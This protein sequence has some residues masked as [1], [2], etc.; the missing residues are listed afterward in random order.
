MLAAG[1]LDAL[2][3]VPGAEN[4]A[5]RGHLVEIVGGRGGRVVAHL[6]EPGSGQLALAACRLLLHPAKRNNHFP[7]GT[8]HGAAGPPPAAADGR[9]AAKGA[10]ACGG[11][12]AGM[13]GGAGNGGTGEK[14]EISTK[15]AGE[16][17]SIGGAPYLT[18]RP[19][20]T[21]RKARNAALAAEGARRQ[22]RRPSAPEWPAPARSARR[23][24]APP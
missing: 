18:R 21:R 2:G 11:R 19:P 12:P 5:E 13:T 4:P 9:S 17:R 6:V 14:R 22:R 16:R 7:A 10:S 8:P 23:D 3:A 24:R 15:G 1:H 20:R